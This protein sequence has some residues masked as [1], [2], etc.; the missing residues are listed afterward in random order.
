MLIPLQMLLDEHDNPVKLNSVREFL[1]VAGLED[2]S[3]TSSDL[4][5][6]SSSTTSEDGSSRRA[7]F[8]DVTGSG[9]APAKEQQQQLR[10]QQRQRPQQQRAASDVEAK[11]RLQAQLEQ[12]LASK[13]KVESRVAG[14]QQENAQLRQQL[15]GVQATAS[16]LQTDLHTRDNELQDTR[17]LL[18][19]SK[20]QHEQLEQSL[21]RTE[22]ALKAIE[23]APAADNAALQA[24]NERLAE[25]LTESQ[26]AY[27][28]HEER[29]RQL[30]LEVEQLRS[31]S[32][33]QVIDA[34]TL[35]DML[36]SSR[37][38]SRLIA[39]R[40][41][42]NGAAAVCELKDGVRVKVAT[43]VTVFHVGKFKKGLSLEGLEGTVL[44][45]ESQYKGQKLSANLPWKVQFSVPGPE[46]K[47]V[48]VIAHLAEDELQVVD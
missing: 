11:R 32:I 17:R 12:G 19:L 2:S 18:R 24:E 5:S 30:A 33:D 15:Q 7:P 34:S 42:G 47:D 26:Q 22:A 38:A 31:A 27:K 1:A 3:E 21:L 8:L 4:C 20:S 29:L 40:S 41:A 43:P 25:Q 6:N 36:S 28:A 23:T 46:G 14:L 16:R 37:A 35:L 39:V 10:P 44:S 48:K 9:S 45:D 13:N